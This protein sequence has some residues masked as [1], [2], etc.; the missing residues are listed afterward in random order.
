VSTQTN[1]S[2][3]STNSTSVN[4]Q[5]YW[6]AWELLCNVV[7]AIYFLQFVVANGA[8]LMASFR[9]STL[10]LLFKVSADAIFHLVRR[11]AKDISL[12]PYDWV[13]GIVGAY[14]NFFYLAV[15]GHD[16][17]GGTLLQIVGLFLAVFAMISLNRSIGFVAANRGVKSDGM[18]RWVR[19]PLYMAYMVSFFGFLLNHFT[20][21]NLLVYTIM[22]TCLYLRSRSEERVLLR[23]PEYQEYSQR[24]RY[25]LIPFVI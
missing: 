2:I 15:E 11:P 3:L 24:V 16:N 18:Y 19:H 17:L 9:L 5:H 10:L 14:T 7:L 13:I 4:R 12:N 25:R 23:D 6:L 22:A 21:H 8:S 1:D 20:V